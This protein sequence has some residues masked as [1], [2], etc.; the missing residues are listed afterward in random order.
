MKLKRILAIL[1][2]IAL[3]MLYASTLVFALIDHP[4]SNEL[5]IVSIIGTFFIPI[6]LYA[7][8][9]MNNALNKNNDDK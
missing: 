9:L 4:Q 1:G 6:I 3:V 8:K 7:I 2:V 5:L